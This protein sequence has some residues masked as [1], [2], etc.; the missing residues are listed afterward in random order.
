MLCD[1]SGMDS[2]SDYLRSLLTRGRLEK[3]ELRTATWRS[4]DGL[5]HN[6]IDYILLPRRFKSSISK[7]KVR[8]YPGADI[9][10]DHDLVLTNLKL[11]LQAKR[12]SNT[13]RIHFDLE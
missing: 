5:V 12:L 4:L 1:H 11:K 13:P 6:Q 10:R 3:Q 7:A 9:G 2:S 8:A